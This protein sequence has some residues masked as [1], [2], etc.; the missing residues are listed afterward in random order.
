MRGNDFRTFAHPP[1]Q[2]V[3]VVRS[4]GFEPY[5]RRGG[6]WRGIALARTTPGLR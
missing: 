1:E 3:E 2:M 5:A 4:A 6:I